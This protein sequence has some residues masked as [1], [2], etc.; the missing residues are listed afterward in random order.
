MKAR[1]LTILCLALT[2]VAVGCDKARADN[3]A[4][5]EANAEAP[6]E[7]K[8]GDDEEA[9]PEEAK[10]EE[11]KQEEAKQGEL[12][13]VEVAKAGQK[14][15]P[16]IQAEQ[17]PAGAWYCDMGTVHWAAMEKPE[18]GKCPECNMALKQHD[19]GKLAEQKEK[20]VEAKEDHGHEHGEGDDH[21]H[22]HAE[23]DHGHAH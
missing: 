8:A 20:A 5:D 23:G 21:G 6:A 14:F 11:A 15:D 1:I 19:P 17:L 7:Q 12:E 13:Q 3:H 16:A 2:L 22:E 9:K 18:G 4:H 10:Q